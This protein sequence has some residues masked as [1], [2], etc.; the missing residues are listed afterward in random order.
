M[1]AVKFSVEWPN[2]EK[3]TYYSPSTIIHQYFEVGQKL[4]IEDFVKQSQEALSHASKRV[5]AKYGVAC[6]A[7]QDQIVKITQKAE[8]Y[9]SES[10]VSFIG[11]EE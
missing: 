6:S 1:P 10:V 9:S 4:N 2:G 11:F 5:E 8:Q 3:N 7:A